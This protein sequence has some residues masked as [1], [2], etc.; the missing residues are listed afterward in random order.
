[1]ARQGNAM[2]SAT[3]QRR[4]LMMANSDNPAH[5]VLLASG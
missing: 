2:K 3:V 4:L 5:E 1:M